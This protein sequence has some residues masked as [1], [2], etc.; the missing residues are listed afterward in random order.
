MPDDPVPPAVVPAPAELDL[1]T[2]AAF[3]SELDHAFRSGAGVVVADMG[4]T[5]F[6][7]SSGLKV[8]VHAAQRAQASG[9]RFE[10][11]RPARMLCR[12]VDILGA[13]SLL[14]LAGD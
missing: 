13:S 7:D 4:A 11:R 5:T 2:A 14:G 12:M 10:L 1:A 8:L 3:R 6:C 9:Q